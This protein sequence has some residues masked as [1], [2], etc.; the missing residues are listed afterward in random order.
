[1]QVGL[2]VGS[3]LVLLPLPNFFRCEVELWEVSWT[4]SLRAATG[5]AWSAVSSVV[6]VLLVAVSATTVAQSLTVAVA[7]LTSASTVS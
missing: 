1:M 5:R 7:R 4:T 3:N 2:A 6:R